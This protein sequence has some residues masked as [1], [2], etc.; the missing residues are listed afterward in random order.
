MPPRLHLRTLVAVAVLAACQSSPDA[1]STSSTSTTATTTTTPATTTTIDPLAL[2]GVMPEHGMAYRT[3]GGTSVA[4]PTGE[5][6]FTMPGVH[7]VDR[8]RDTS[9]MAAVVAFDAD[10][11]A[12]PA[13]YALMIGES[14][15]VPVGPAA[16]SSP[17]VVG[18]TAEGAPAGCV[19]DAR[20]PGSTLLLCSVAPHPAPPRIARAGSDG[21]VQEVLPVAPPLPSGHWVNAIEGPGGQIAAT[22]SGECESLSAYLVTATGEVTPL[23]A[24]RGATIQGWWGGQVLVSRFGGCEAAGP[25]DG[26]FLVGADGTEQRVLTEAATEVPV[27]W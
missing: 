8:S 11:E 16:D 19:R 14:R 3:S 22:W 17:Y 9:T 15:M 24:G 1:A 12:L 27:V 26:L 4:A 23:S 10:T 5:V 2:P 6:L 25:G 18:W 21:A 13:T 7:I 20:R